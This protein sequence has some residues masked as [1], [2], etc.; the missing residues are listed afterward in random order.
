M[1]IV[2][3][4]D[5]VGP[6]ICKQ[7]FEIDRAIFKIGKPLRN[8]PWVS[9]GN[10]IL[11]HPVVTLYT[12]SIVICS[13]HRL[14]L[15]HPFPGS[16]IERQGQTTN[17]CFPQHVSHYPTV[18]HPHEGKARRTREKLEASR[19]AGLTW[20]GEHEMAAWITKAKCAWSSAH[21]RTLSR[22]PKN[23]NMIEIRLSVSNGQKRREI[24]RTREQFGSAKRH[25]CIAHYLL[26]KGPM[27]IWTLFGN[28]HYTGSCVIIIIMC[29]LPQSLQE[30]GKRRFQ[31]ICREYMFSDVDKNDNDL[32]LSG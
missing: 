17:L 25:D 27:F 29:W 19:I 14:L 5:P 32:T 7:I 23:S 16:A 4:R 6:L 26:P 10:G 15:I 21:T 18:N 30:L 12:T 24:A 1:S 11:E 22:L 31:S 3:D 20:S 9:A 28:Q 2:S 8:W 13:C